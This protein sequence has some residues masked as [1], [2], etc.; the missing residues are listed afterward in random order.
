MDIEERLK[1]EIQD[2]YINIST[3]RDERKVLG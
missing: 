2:K 3:P 1:K